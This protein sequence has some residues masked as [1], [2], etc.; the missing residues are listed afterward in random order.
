MFFFSRVN[1]EEYVLRYDGSASIDNSTSMT[2]DSKLGSSKLGDGSNLRS[3]YVSVY[4]VLIVTLFI[5][6]LIRAVIEN[7]V[8]IRVSTNI[9]KRMFDA[10]I[11]ATML[12][13]DKNPSGITTLKKKIKSRP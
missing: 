11:K 1:E 13:F 8:F 10:I 6:I 4:T 7:S 5:T 12:F 2:Q 3:T 9:H